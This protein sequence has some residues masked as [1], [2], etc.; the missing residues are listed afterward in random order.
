MVSI[1]SNPRPKAIPKKRIIT[2]N[3]FKIKTMSMKL[4]LQWFANYYNVIHV[5]FK[6]WYQGSFIEIDCNEGSFTKNT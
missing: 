3:F 6:G 4:N 1:I 5:K 2:N